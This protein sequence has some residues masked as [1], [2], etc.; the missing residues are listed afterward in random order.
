MW[1]LGVGW[2]KIGKRLYEFR[3]GN[4]VFPVGKHGKT[5]GARLSHGSVH[6]SYC[7]LGHGID[8]I[9]CLSYVLA[10]GPHLL[11]PP[12]VY[13]ILQPCLP[14]DDSKLEN[15]VAPNSYATSPANSY[16]ISPQLY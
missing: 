4:L 11:G 14:T 9:P 7:L 6:Q 13:Y 3:S 10:K 5:K 15:A 16:V 1:Q 2:G 12:S 8:A